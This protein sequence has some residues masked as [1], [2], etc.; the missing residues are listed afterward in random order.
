MTYSIAHITVLERPGIHFRLDFLTHGLGPG[1]HGLKKNGSC[2]HSLFRNPVIARGFP[3]LARNHEE[4]VLEIPLNMMAKLGE[5]SRAMNFDGILAI[6]GF[7]T[8]FVPTERT[9]NS[10]LWHFL[11]EESQNRI[12]Y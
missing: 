2:W 6:R 5:A 11:Y 3:I 8:L 4:K 9:G 12:S 7:S 1:E 10:V